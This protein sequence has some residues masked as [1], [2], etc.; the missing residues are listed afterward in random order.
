MATQS[1]GS[2]G[3]SQTFVKIFEL[4]CGGLAF[5]SCVPSSCLMNAFGLA[6]PSCLL[7]QSWVLVSRELISLLHLSLAHM[8]EDRM[9]V[10]QEVS[11]A[12][13]TVNPEE[14]PRHSISFFFCSLSM[15]KPWFPPVL[16][17]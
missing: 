2:E 17:C 3:P 8:D 5:P 11:I 7:Q 1:R 14:G 16:V 10:S 12:K 9:T 6:L 15:Q 4:G 13:V